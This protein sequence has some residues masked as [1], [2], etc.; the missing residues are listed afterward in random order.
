[1]GNGGI[2][3]IKGDLLLSLN[4]RLQMSVSLYGDEGDLEARR[5][6]DE[7]EKIVDVGTE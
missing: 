1:M 6:L 5:E 4:E 7:A 2:Y 3:V